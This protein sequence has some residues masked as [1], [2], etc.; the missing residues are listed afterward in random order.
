MLAFAL[1][2]KYGCRLIGGW[3]GDPHAAGIL[4]RAIALAAARTH[5]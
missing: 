1:I 5:T 2:G 4:A 3:Q